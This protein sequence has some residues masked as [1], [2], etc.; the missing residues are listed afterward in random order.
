MSMQHHNQKLAQSLIFQMHHTT[1][2]TILIQ[3]VAVTGYDVN[4]GIHI[5]VSDVERII[6]I[7]LNLSSSSIR[8]P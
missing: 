7:S 6:N 4:T 1:K 8:A 3:K 2:D 5:H